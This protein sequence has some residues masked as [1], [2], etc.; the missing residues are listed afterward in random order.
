LQLFW[1]LS[2]FNT[3]RSSF[4][5]AVVLHRAA[6]YLSPSTFVPNAAPH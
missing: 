2:R 5:R 3:A 6:A 4:V 1:V